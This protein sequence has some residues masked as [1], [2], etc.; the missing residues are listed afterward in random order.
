[1]NENTVIIL[2]KENG[3]IS[4]KITDPWANSPFEKGAACME[5]VA[6]ADPR[7]LL[8][9]WTSLWL[10]SR[11]VRGKGSAFQHLRMDSKSLYL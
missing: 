6:G 2:G 8:G 7:S 4:G 1:M 5:K 3:D 10:K 11:G 9:G